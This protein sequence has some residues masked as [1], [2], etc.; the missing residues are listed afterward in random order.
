M[1]R[2][3][4]LRHFPTDWNAKRRLQ[5]RTDRPLMGVSQRELVA[6]AL[7]PPW[8]AVPVLASPLGRARE[9]AE[10]LA[11]DRFSGTDQRLTE[12]DF[13]D[14]EGQLIEPLLAD[15]TSLYV[16]MT[17]WGWDRRAPGGESPADVFERVR[18]LLAGLTEPTLLIAHKGLMR[19]ILARA[20]G[21]DYDG[22]EPFTIKKG[23][24]YPLTIG[25]GGIPSAPEA[26]VRL[27]AR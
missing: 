22:P 12:M 7:P 6:Q 27:L 1:I 24:L 21:W 20:W 13:G 26:P 18:P 15:P 10:L 19:A 2:I 14:W 5:G 17:E 4:L 8:N 11:G 9:T 16:P 3:A 23:R 25:P